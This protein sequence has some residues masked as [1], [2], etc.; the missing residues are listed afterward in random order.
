MEMTL[1]Y[2]QYQLHYYGCANTVIHNKNRNTFQAYHFWDGQLPGKDYLYIVSPSD[3]GRISPLVAASYT[4]FIWQGETAADLKD[5]SNALILKDQQNLP[6]MINILNQIFYDYYDWDNLLKLGE[7]DRLTD[8]FRQCQSVFH[9]PLILIDQFFNTIAQTPDIRL[10]PARQ[11]P[12][13]QELVMAKKFPDSQGQ[14]KPFIYRDDSTGQLLLCKNLKINGHFFARLAGEITDEQLHTAVTELFARLSASLEEML[15]LSC[16]LSR[17]RVPKKSQLFRQC[18]E[19]LSRGKDPENLEP[20]DQYGWR[21]HDPYDVV[22]FE[23][24]RDLP[25]E[26]SMEYISEQI[27]ALCYDCYTMLEDSV[28][29][30]LRNLRL[31]LYSKDDFHQEIVYFLRENVIKSGFSMIFTDLKKISLY[32]H[33]AREALC[34]GKKYNPTQWCYLFSKYQL[35]HLLSTPYPPKDVCCRALLTLMEIDRKK[36]SDLYQTLKCYLNNQ[37]NATK[38]SDQLFIHRTTLIYRIKTI[39]ELTGINLENPD[40]YLHLLLSCRILEEPDHLL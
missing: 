5:F 30:C 6:G 2:L 40:T 10:L 18:L 32:K 23:L 38:T 24:S 1:E 25:P 34:L 14:D 16:G 29:Y 39:S 20:L 8:L 31:S 22:I 21:L 15:A 26:T 36:G 17:R 37:C 35:Q 9:F 28:L 11:E 33:Q 3:I 19:T 12:Y 4:F 27:T 7:P 13:I